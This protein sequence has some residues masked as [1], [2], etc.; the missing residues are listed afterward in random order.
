[1]KQRCACKPVHGPQLFAAAASAGT[2]AVLQAR[3]F[4]RFDILGTQAC[5]GLI[6]TDTGP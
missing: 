3:L 2:T 1:M 4:D 5:F 6:H